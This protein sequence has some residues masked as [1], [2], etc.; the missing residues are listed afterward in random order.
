MFNNTLWILCTR[1]RNLLQIKE[2]DNILL[3]VTSFRFRQ[4]AKLTMINP[5]AQGFFIRPFFGLAISFIK[6]YSKVFSNN[7]QIF[8]D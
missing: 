6:I 3:Q 5:L 7:F 1:K 8:I 4:C 2:A